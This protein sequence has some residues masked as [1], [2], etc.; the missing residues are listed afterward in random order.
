[1]QKH[2]SSQKPYSTLK[3][4]GK[5]LA[6]ESGLF[7]G[8]LQGSLGLQQLFLFGLH[9]LATGGLALEIALEDLDVALEFL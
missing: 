1:M 6:L 7:D 9:F 3:F 2:F 8:L 5:V 4:V